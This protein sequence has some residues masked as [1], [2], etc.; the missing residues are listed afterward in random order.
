M[1]VTERIMAELYAQARAAL[2]ALGHPNVRY[3]K[4]I[5]LLVSQELGV[6]GMDSAEL[7]KKFLLQCSTSR[8]ASS[9]KLV[10]IRPYKPDL[11]MRQAAARCTNIPQQIGIH[12]K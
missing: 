1:K 5:I 3:R 11:A 7:L 4:E 2:M 12:S 9:F 10:K 6:G 8:R